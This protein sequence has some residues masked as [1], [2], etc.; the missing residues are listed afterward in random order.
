MLRF[1]AV[2]NSPLPRKISLI[3]VRESF[4]ISAGD[5]KNANLFYSAG[6]QV[7]SGL[8]YEKM[9]PLRAGDICLLGQTIP[10]TLLVA[11]F[12]Q[13]YPLNMEC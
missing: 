13:S 6:F 5:G 3:S 4:D 8:G 1:V 7:L 2:P 12:H 9:L 10:L 11:A